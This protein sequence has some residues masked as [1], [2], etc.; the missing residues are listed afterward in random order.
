MAA[1]LED[2]FRDAMKAP[3]APPGLNRTSLNG[4][5]IPAD[6][7]LVIDGRY[8]EEWWVEFWVGS[9]GEVTPVPRPLF[10]ENGIKFRK[11]KAKPRE[12][13]CQI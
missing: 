7:V 5:G 10:K 2:G 3:R 13:R 4:E 1:D 6:R 9:P 12:F 8:L 11:G